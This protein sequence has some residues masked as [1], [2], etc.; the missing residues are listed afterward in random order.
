MGEVQAQAVSSQ[1]RNYFKTFS[2]CLEKLEKLKT[3]TI[4]CQGEVRR[5]QVLEDLTFLTRQTGL[6]L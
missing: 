2:V 3:F 4:K 1:K 6:R 5:P